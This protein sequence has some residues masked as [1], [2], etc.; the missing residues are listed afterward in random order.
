MDKRVVLFD[1]GSNLRWN[2]AGARAFGLDAA[3]VDR[4][5]EHSELPGPRLSMLEELLL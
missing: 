2:V 1:L 4:A 3:F 5:G